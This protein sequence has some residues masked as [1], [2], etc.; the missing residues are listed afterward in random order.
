MTPQQVE[1]RKRGCSP[2]TL[3]IPPQHALITHGPAVQTA[4]GARNLHQSEGRRQTTVGRNAC[5]QEVNHGESF[6]T[7]LKLK[8]TRSRS[9]G[10]QLCCLLLPIM[11]ATLSC[12]LFSTRAFWSPPDVPQLQN[13]VQLNNPT[14]FPSQLPLAAADHTQLV[15]KVVKAGGSHAHAHAPPYLGCRRRAPRGGRRVSASFWRQ[16]WGSR[17]LFSAVE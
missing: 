7:Y 9:W 1:R 14:L 11:G 16:V 4:S 17:T 3:T 2:E 5:L 8:T 10:Q 12:P 6:H 15:H 13:T